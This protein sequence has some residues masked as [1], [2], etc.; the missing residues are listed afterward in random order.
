M[1]R[2]ICIILTALA[3]MVGTAAQA[4][5]NPLDPGHKHG[6]KLDSVDCNAR[7]RVAIAVFEESDQPCSSQGGCPLVCFYQVWGEWPGGRTDTPW[8]R[9]HTPPHVEVSDTSAAHIYEAKPS[10]VSGEWGITVRDGYGHRET[11]RCIGSE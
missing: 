11:T 5:E 6:W 1:K 10:W 2:S 4:H 8:K 7:H 9:C 3:V